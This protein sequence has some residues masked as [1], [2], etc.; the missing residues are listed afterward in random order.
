[1]PTTVTERGI[2]SAIGIAMLALLGI[3]IALSTSACS[4]ACGNQVVERIAS[5]DKS[6]IIYIFERDCGA[7]TDFVTH[8]AVLAHSDA[9]GNNTVGDVFVADSNRGKV[10]FTVHAKWISPS[11]IEIAYPSGSRVYTKAADVKGVRVS[12]DVF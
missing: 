4:S 10:N 8:I 11:A 5:P 12:Y 6:K 7:T 2:R 9:F 1:M 3:F